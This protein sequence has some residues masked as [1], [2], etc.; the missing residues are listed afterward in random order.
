MNMFAK[1]KKKIEESGGNV[2]DSERNHSPVPGHASP[3]RPASNSS[4][5]VVQ[6]P[7][8]K[9]KLGY[10]SDTSSRTNPQSPTGSVRDEDVSSSKEEI[11]AIL[12][13]RTE[14]CKKL[15]SKISEYAAIIKDKNK[16]LEKM[17]TALEKQQDANAKR[18]QELNE[19]YQASRAKMS[20]GFTLALE[21]KDEE[22]QEL[23][24]K[25]KE[26]EEYKHKLFKRE[27]EN[28]EFQGLATQE[29]A[30]VKHMLLN[31]QEE[32]A[33]LK[34]ETQTKT[35]KLDKSETQVKELQNQVTSLTEQVKTFQSK[36][37]K[38]EEESLAQAALVNSIVDEQQTLQENKKKQTEE[39]TE[40][41]NQLTTQVAE[42][43]ELENNYQ[44]LQRNFEMHK[45]KTEVLL[46]EKDD[47]IE[48]LQDRI[49]ML[50]QRFQD[51]SLSGDDRVTALEA[52]R[53]SVE[54]KL[55]ETR[56]QL[57]QIK[58][59]WSEKI[60]HLEQQIENLQVKLDDAEKRAKENWQLAQKKDS[61]YQDEKHNLETKL[62]KL[63]LEKID[64]ET[65]LRAKITSLESQLTSLEEAKEHEKMAA[66]SKI[67][68]LEKKESDYLDKI[69]H[70]EKKIEDV[71][72]DRNKIVNE[73]VTKTEELQKLQ[74]ENKKQKSELSQLK[75]KVIAYE[76]QIR[77][78][79]EKLDKNSKTVKDKHTE[80]QDCVKE[81]DELL[82]R[83]AELSQELK[84]LQTS[85]DLRFKE[86]EDLL[87]PYPLGSVKIEDLENK[88]ENS[89]QSGRQMEILQKTVVDLE[90]QL[91]EKNKT[92]KKQEQRLTDLKKT[93]QREL[94]VQ[95]L[96]ND[97]PV[98]M[99]GSLQTPPLQRKNLTESPRTSPPKLS[100]ENVVTDPYNSSHKQ[101]DFHVKTGFKP[102]ANSVG[103]IYDGRG[104][105]PLEKDINFQ[106][107]KHVV[108]KFMLSRESE[109]I[110]LI[111]AVSMLLKFTIEE[112]RLI[113]ETLEYKM[114]W[115]G[116]KPSSGS[117]QLKKVIPPS[118]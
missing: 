114:S 113:K 91:L 43:S 111:R 34:E 12:M 68:H 19:Q 20:E 56:Q 87:M 3:L 33:T 42:K 36:C 21:K 67:E 45:N 53:T 1:L 30:K 15:E 112:Q 38:L 52:E 94:K 83:N 116:S 65:Q 77:E 95:A 97:D 102:S 59:S 110:Q 104:A 108:L 103:E 7:L 50:E 18:I 105:H 73:N 89:L 118:Y 32:L 49:K 61:T 99:D 5:N 27:E 25:I 76:E 35:E 93:L 92:L 54:N 9:D 82:L 39:L 17:E 51:Q 106:Y 23:I 13:K 90:Q 46:Q 88:H 80:L 26:I 71:E 6:S 60:N 84:T 41:S 98:V 8:S 31:T 14:Q 109:A 62:N 72:Q 40:I 79:E 85:T 58:S 16:N 63:E 55:E 75:D 48:Q 115:F 96:P 100:V 47:H 24:D 69:L 117:G 74:E 2:S 44:S 57:T 4:G 81:K 66:D 86:L 64:L 78:T 22:K 37:Y 107:L 70:M 10:E 101:S 11:L 28:D 29:L